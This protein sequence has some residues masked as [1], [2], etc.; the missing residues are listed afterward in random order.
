MSRLERSTFSIAQKSNWVAAAAVVAMMALTCADVT[1]RLFRHPIPGTYEMVG[2]LGAIV[3]SF[4]LAHTS[5]MRGHI[6]VE[7]IVQKLPKRVQTVID[8]INSLIGA[9]LFGLI[10][11]QSMLYASN[12]MRTGEVSMTLQMPIY[13]FVYGIAI[14]SGM[15]CLVLLIE[16]LQSL[17]RIVRK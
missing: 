9:A 1:L 3:V 7:F 5:V 11:W 10:T 14:G 8:G 6:A 15:L 17:K 12:L 2:L 13:P 16:F 4:S